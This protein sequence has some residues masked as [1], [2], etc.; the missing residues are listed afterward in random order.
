MV[1]LCEFLCEFP[2][3]SCIRNLS[4]SLDKVHIRGFYTQNHGAPTQK[5]SVL[6]HSRFHIN[7]IVP[8]SSSFSNITPHNMKRFYRTP[9]LH[10][11]K[12][13]QSVS[14]FQTTWRWDISR[15]QRQANQF[16]VHLLFLK[17]NH[18][19]Q[20]MTYEGFEASFQLFKF[21]QHSIFYSRHKYL[22][23]HSKII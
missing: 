22:N 23:T 15:Q 3:E 8:R 6:H 21:L 7:W 4:W 9:H 13:F 10:P 16:R 19:P 14:S 5:T 1:E 12:P 17:L 20:R 2:H 11:E 18:G